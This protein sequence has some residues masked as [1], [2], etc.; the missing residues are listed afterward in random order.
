MQ[1]VEQYIRLC[2]LRPTDSVGR[3]LE[4]TLAEV[5]AILCCT[6]RNATL[7]LKKMQ[8]RGWL[9]WQ[10]GRGRGNHSVLTLLLEPA[11]LLLS[12]AKELAQTG[13][14][15]ASQELMQQYGEAWPTFSQN[16]SLWMKSQFGARVTR[17][18]GSN[19]RVDTL[20]LLLDRPFEALDPIHVLL[21]SQTHLVKHLFDTLVRFDPLT[22]R[23]EPQLAFHWETDESGKHWTFYLRKGV[24]FH[25]GRLLTADDVRFSLLRLM[26]QSFKHRW[27]A[28]SIE[29]VNVCDDYVVTIELKER[30]ELFLQAL[31]K[32]Q[33]SI[34]P[35]D[36][37]EQM[38]E[39]FSRL[40][41]GTGPFRVVRHDDSMLVLEAFAPYFAGRP[42]LDKI[43]IWCVPGMGQA[44]W[45]DESVLTVAKASSLQEAEA[46][47]AWN[48]VARQEKCFQYVSLNAAKKGPLADA[49]FRSL[50]AELLAGPALREELQGGREQAEVWGG[51]RQTAGSTPDDPAEIA[52]LVDAR[53]YGKETLSLYTYPDADHIEDAEWIR[54]KAKAYGIPIEIQY[55]TPEELALP[56]LLQHADLVV[57][58]ANVDERT[59]LSLVEFLLAEALSITH[60]LT[61]HGKAELERLI[62][63][64]GQ[65][66]LTEERQTIVRT[67]ME[68]LMA[69]HIFVPLYAN[70]V[71]MKA[72][73]RLSG[74]SLDAYGWIDFRTVF[75]R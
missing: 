36:Y 38:G 40:P 13:E 4:I 26:E 34:V 9:G 68:K 45:A 63:S 21:R 47:L 55:A 6:L 20:R 57:D 56:A 11:D 72:H 15:R 44:D 61:A 30:D 28:R 10:P 18:K 54:D 69:D 33:L 65:T 1:L 23:I 32:E 75:G 37:T 7:T 35:R 14:I 52:R 48:E 16:F 70:R 74:I 67:M 3:P 17:E 24:L 5:A 66:T 22:K 58:S 53:G 62:R 12:V 27:L 71:E 2:A 8:A 25:H 31:S 29:S 43:E 19:S 39:Q 60:H 49:S 41:V 73:P 46:E 50:L 51:Y 64:L 42:F 59:E